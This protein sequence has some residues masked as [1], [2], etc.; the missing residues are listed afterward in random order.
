M[1]VGPGLDPCL[2]QG[3]NFAKKLA[4]KWKKPIVPVNHLEAHLLANFLPKIGS[5]LQL[6]ID[7]LQKLFPA[8]GL[9]V[10]GGHT[11]LVLMNDIG[12]YRI[13]GETRDDAAG[14]CLDKVARILGLGYP[15]GP[16]IAKLATSYKLQATSYK[17]RHPAND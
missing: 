3:I 5:N 6:T 17:I 10:S 15:G 8:I 9:V 13:L 16:E 7:N 4:E 11:E 14:E 1:T 2:W 12:K